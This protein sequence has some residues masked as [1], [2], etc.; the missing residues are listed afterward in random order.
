MRVLLRIVAMW[1]T[2]LL[3]PWAA[4]T[5][6]SGAVSPDASGAVSPAA[7]SPVPTY[8]SLRPAADRSDTSTERG[9]AAGLHPN[10]HCCRTLVARAS[11]RPEALPAP[12][13]PAYAY[14]GRPAQV[15][16][17]STTTREHVELADRELSPSEWSVTAAKAVDSFLPGLPKTAPKPLGLGSTGLVE[18]ASLTEQLAMTSGRADPAGAVIPR[19]VMSDARW[20][21][22]DGWVKMQQIENG[23]NIHYVRNT[24]TGAVDDFKFK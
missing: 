2:C 22:A 21:A 15:A 4:P 6:A 3:L 23:V 11:A 7:H 1:L 16:R 5:D 19:V 10:V 24:I 14:F 9:P 8:D 12:S 17:P 18:P 13:E 20:P